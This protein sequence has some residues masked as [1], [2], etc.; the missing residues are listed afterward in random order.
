MLST[1]VVSGESNSVS[2]LLSEEWINN[3]LPDL[4]EGYEPRNI[5]NADEFGIFFKMLPKKSLYYKGKRCKGGKLSKLRITGYL[6]TKMDGS[7]KQKLII[8]GKYEKSRYFKK[9]KKLP[10]IYYNNSAAWMTKTIFEDI[11]TKFN[12]KMLKEKRHI[13]LFVDNCSSHMLSKTFKIQFD[14]LD[15]VI[16]NE[17]SWDCVTQ[18]TII[19]C[20]S[21]SGFVFNDAIVTTNLNEN[22]DEC[23]ENL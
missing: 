18:N 20:F 7:D 11:K 23:N 4:L 12:K 10:V 15:A 17:S 3:K 22:F 19:N 16:L 1:Q 9:V 13:L 21:K 8:I 14:L 2:T 6:C 5:Y